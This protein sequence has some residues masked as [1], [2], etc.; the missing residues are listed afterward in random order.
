MYVVRLLLRDLPDT[1]PDELF[2]DDSQ[3]STYEAV[4]VED[5]FEGKTVRFLAYVTAEIDASQF[6]PRFTIGD[7]TQTDRK[8]QF[9]NAGLQADSLYAFFLR[10]Y[11]KTKGDSL[12]SSR[13]RRQSSSGASTRQY[14]VFSSSGYTRISKTGN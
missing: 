2:N 11:P 9:P 10:A 1:P 4:N 5:A 6:K 14:V 3:I 7:G 12:S 13:A 8:D